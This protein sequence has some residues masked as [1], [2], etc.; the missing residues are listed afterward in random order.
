MA[1]DQ[2]NRPDRQTRAANRIE[3][4]AHLRRR[5]LD[6]E[7]E[8]SRLRDALHRIARHCAGRDGELGGMATIAW[9]TLRG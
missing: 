6:L 9:E 3:A 8:N 7:T 5:F 2:D 4:L 1:P